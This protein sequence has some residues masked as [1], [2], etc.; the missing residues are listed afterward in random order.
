MVAAGRPGPAAAGRQHA[1]PI[2]LQTC[3]ASKTIL[4]AVFEFMR[5]D[6]D[7]KPIP[8]FRIE[9]ENVNWP[10]VDFSISQPN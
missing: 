3:A 9:L 4:Q 5:A 7:S 6:G 1:S 10:N 2:V 8:Y